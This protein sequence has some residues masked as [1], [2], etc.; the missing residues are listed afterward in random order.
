MKKPVK[1]VDLSQFTPEQKS[2]L[3]AVIKN[4]K[5]CGPQVQEVQDTA[6][7]LYRELLR[8]PTWQVWEA[9][10]PDGEQPGEGWHVA[11]TL[12]YLPDNY[13]NNSEGSEV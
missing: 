13:F 1:R 8:S 3:I 9:P 12:N 5:A 11:P 7:A 4:A 10:P 2:A 6:I